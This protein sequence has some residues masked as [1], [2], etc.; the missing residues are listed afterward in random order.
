MGEKYI[1]L[2]WAYGSF[3]PHDSNQER[4]YSTMY[5]MQPM[6]ED[7]GNSKGSGFRAEKL[8]CVERIWEG[9]DLVPF[10]QIEVFFD[11]YSRAIGLKVTSRYSDKPSK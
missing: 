7:G 11:R 1:F 8:R 5:V 6:A 10:D 9:Q 4:T 3:T 2:G